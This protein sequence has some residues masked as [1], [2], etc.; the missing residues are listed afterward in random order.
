MKIYV[1]NGYESL[2][3]SQYIPVAAEKECQDELER[4]SPTNP[5]PPKDCP[6]RSFG[7]S[8]VQLGQEAAQLSQQPAGAAEE[9]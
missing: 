1:F 6:A 2:Y 5:D 9:S 3:V 8:A 4:I 7:P